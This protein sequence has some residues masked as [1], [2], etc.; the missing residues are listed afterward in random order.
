MK[1]YS[2]GRH[3]GRR[4]RPKMMSMIRRTMK[5][6]KPL[7]RILIRGMFNFTASFRAMYRL[8]AI[9]RIPTR[10]TVLLPWKWDLASRVEAMPAK[11]EPGAAAGAEALSGRRAPERTR[12]MKRKSLLWALFLRWR[13]WGT[14]LARQLWGFMQSS[15]T[16][17]WIIQAYQARGSL[18]SHMG[19]KHNSQKR[20]RSSSKVLSQEAPGLPPTATSVTYRTP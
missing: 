10:S 3:W 12:M 1:S 7:E 13:A 9:C 11:A 17:I 6:M 19:W 4:E 15:V 2:T 5:S 20:H 18:P 14:L 8:M 16:R